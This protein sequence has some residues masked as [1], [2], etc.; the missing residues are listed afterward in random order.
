MV[1]PIQEPREKVPKES[2]TPEN[3]LKSNTASDVNIDKKTITT[4]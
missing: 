3:K 2:K 1:S 4:L